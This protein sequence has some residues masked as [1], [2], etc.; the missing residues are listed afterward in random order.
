MVLS[1]FNI[2]SQTV[3]MGE[4]DLTIELCM[5]LKGWSA[6]RPACPTFLKISLLTS[7][8]F[9]VSAFAGLRQDVRISFALSLSGIS[10]HQALRMGSR[11]CEIG[12]EV[13]SGSSF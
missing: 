6:S 9:C 12:S 4:A 3:M 8:G 2:W 11:C 7:T 13:G 1:A 10:H 5:Y